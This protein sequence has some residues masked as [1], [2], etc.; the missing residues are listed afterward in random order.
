MAAIPC[1]RTTKRLEFRPTVH[2]AAPRRPFP[3]PRDARQGLFRSL[4]KRHFLPGDDDVLGAVAQLDIAVRKAHAKIARAKP[5]VGSGRREWPLRRDNS[6][7][8]RCSRGSDFAQRFAVGRYFIAAASITLISLVTTLPTPC[9]AFNLAFSLSGFAFHS[10]CQS[11]ITEG[12][13]VSVKPYKCVTCKSSEASRAAA[14]ESEA[15][16]R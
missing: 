5:S 16:P 1:R 12:P 13:Y 4:P 14:R 9:R 8:S 2:P 11:L 3:K 6:R 10:G 7:W 15:R